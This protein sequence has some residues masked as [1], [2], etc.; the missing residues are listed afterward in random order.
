MGVDVKYEA[1]KEGIESILA[2][3]HT[4]SF[5]NESAVKIGWKPKHSCNPIE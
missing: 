4:D 1:P 3:I 5:D 2:E